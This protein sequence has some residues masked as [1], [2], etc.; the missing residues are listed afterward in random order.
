MTTVHSNVPSRRSSP[1]S[2]GALSESEIDKSIRTPILLFVGW[3]LFWLLVSSVFALVSS[4]Q[5]HLPQYLEARVLFTYGRV[6][7]VDSTLY[8]Y[9]CCSTAVFAV[10]FRIMSLLSHPRL[11]QGPLLENA[12]TVWN[13]AV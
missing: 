13:L 5:L 8:L 12:G 7:A 10:V 2:R 3:A 1:F 6:Q 11:R 9:G 4:L